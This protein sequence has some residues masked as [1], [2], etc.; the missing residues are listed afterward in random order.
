VFGV[1]DFN[2]VSR[3]VWG[4]EHHPLP[5]VVDLL[6]HG[7]APEGTPAGL[8][9]R[10]P[11]A[12]PTPVPPADETRTRGERTRARI[13]D[14]AG[15]LFGT[16]GYHACTTSKVADTAG[17]G[18][19]TV[20][21]HFESKSALLGELVRRAKTRL[22]AAVADA[23]RGATQRVRVEA[24]ALRAFLHFAV[25]HREL[26][27]IVREAE[28]AEQELGRWYYLEIAEG[29]RHVLGP[30][31]ARGELRELDPLA[32]GLALMG[33]G[34]HLGLRWPVWEGRPVPEDVLV[35]ALDLLQLGALRIDAQRNAGA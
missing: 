23:T 21:R 14:A 28:F 30:A 27:R 24:L 8:W 26:Y 1:V 20:Y 31:V 11:D 33:L 7:L 35:D 34:H 5:T 13:L 16:H 15:A 2:V 22:R 6:L 25:E 18:Q 29:Y 32:L 12:A 10:A 19:G 9:R 4:V 3:A 17:V